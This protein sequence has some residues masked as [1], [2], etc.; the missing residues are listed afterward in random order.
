MSKMLKKTPELASEQELS[1]NELKKLDGF[2]KDYLKPASVIKIL[3][4][5]IYEHHD[6]YDE[7]EADK[8]CF[9]VVF[10]GDIEKDFDIEKLALLQVRAA[11][12][13]VKEEMGRDI[14]PMFN[15]ATPAELNSFG[16][17]A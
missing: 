7:D 3:Q 8:V 12:K 2:V 5:D 1:P 11:Q 15:Y 16:Y 13:Y 9:M 6:I 4:G 17:E 10:E 14:V